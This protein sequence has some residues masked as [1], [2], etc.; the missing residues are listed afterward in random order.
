MRARAHLYMLMHVGVVILTLRTNSEL[1]C[2]RVQSVQSDSSAVSHA[3]TDLWNLFACG[4]IAHLA[5]VKGMFD[6]SHIY[7]LQAHCICTHSSH[8]EV[9]C[10]PSLVKLTVLF[11]EVLKAWSVQLSEKRQEM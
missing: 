3:D 11:V 4:Y 9:W 1:R 5:K 6:I 10:G 2:I 7:C 8:H